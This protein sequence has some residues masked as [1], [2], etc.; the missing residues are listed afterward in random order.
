MDNTIISLTCPKCGSILEGTTDTLILKC[1]YCDNK[2]VVKD[3]ITPLKIDNKDRLAAYTKMAENAIK[4]E[5]FINAESYYKLICEIKSSKENLL[6]YNMCKFFNND[7]DYTENFLDESDILQQQEQLQFL[8]LIYTKLNEH[9]DSE[10]T[11]ALRFCT[12]DSLKK[13]KSSAIKKKYIHPI[14]NVEKKIKSIDDTFKPSSIDLNIN[15]NTKNVS[16]FKYAFIA[17]LILIIIFKFI[18]H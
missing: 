13:S 1:K 14:H 4:T 15:N 8:K 11:E 9:M 7:M 6:K 17:I 16:T 12:T 18:I 5:D 3:F 10:I 2:V